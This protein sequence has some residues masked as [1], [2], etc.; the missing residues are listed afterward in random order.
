MLALGPPLDRFL[1]V[2]RRLFEVEGMITALESAGLFER[3]HFG[4]AHPELARVALDGREPS[5]VVTRE[6]R[7]GADEEGAAA[8]AV[9]LLRVQ[10]LERIRRAVFGVPAV[11]GVSLSC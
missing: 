9:G 3:Q 4:R 6:G 5:L 2:F 10:Q 1:R 7:G 8:V 11:G